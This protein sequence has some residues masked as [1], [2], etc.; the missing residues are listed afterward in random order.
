MILFSTFGLWQTASTAVCENRKL[1]DSP[2]NSRRYH[3][4]S[5]LFPDPYVDFEEKFRWSCEMNSFAGDRVFQ[6]TE[7]VKVTWGCPEISWR[8]NKHCDYKRRFG[9]DKDRS[10]AIFE[11]VSRFS[12]TVT[13]YE[14][15]RECFSTIQDLPMELYYEYKTYLTITVA[16]IFLVVIALVDC[17][18]ENNNLRKS[19]K[20]AI[21]EQERLREE[22][23]ERKMFHNIQET[24]YDTQ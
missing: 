15:S 17:I 16:I 22:L 20:K 7:N 5:D 18:R 8:R 4:A 21:E 3:T 24:N 13:H 10:W 6:E 12:K 14:R 2:E 23:P 9:E 11:R 19:L 1:D